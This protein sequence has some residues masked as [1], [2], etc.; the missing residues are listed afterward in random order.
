[1]RRADGCA[2]QVTERTSPPLGTG[3]VAPDRASEITLESGDLLVLFADGLV[4][5][6]GEDIGCGLARL[7]AIAPGLALADDPALSMVGALAPD[8]ADDV[9][10]VTLR[11]D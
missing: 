1:V 11:I 3:A 6:R 8:A 9:C 7:E 4:E 10:V 5:R 2:R